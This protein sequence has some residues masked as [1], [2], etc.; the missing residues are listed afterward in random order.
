[1]DDAVGTSKVNRKT[2]RQDGEGDVAKTDDNL[3]L[4]V[5][6]QVAENGDV[7]I[8]D[9]VVVLIPD[10]F[11]RWTKLI[12]QAFSGESRPESDLLLFGESA[13]GHQAFLLYAF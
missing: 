12:V 10:G 5:G 7:I 2:V 11:E 6:T 4:R 1:M 13:D 9:V 8:W 3:T